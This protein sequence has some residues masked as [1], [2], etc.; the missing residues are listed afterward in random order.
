MSIF[1]IG[2]VAIHGGIASGHIK[3]STAVLANS[4]PEFSLDALLKVIADEATD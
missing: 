3:V 2:A 1:V 4:K